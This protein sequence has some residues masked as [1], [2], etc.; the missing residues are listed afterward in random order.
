M[1]KKLLVLLLALML[2][3]AVLTACGQRRPAFDGE[4]DD[5]GPRTGAQ[6]D[7]AGQNDETVTVDGEEFDL[8]Y[9]THHGDLYYKT[10][11]VELGPDTAGAWCE[12]SHY[13]DG[14]PLVRIH[15]VYYE[16]KTAGEVMEESGYELTTKVVGDMEYQYFEYDENGMAGHTYVCSFNGTVY[17]ISFVSNA[18]I[19]ALEQTF[20][21]NVSFR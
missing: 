19:S 17:T 5:A 13:K 12:L 16:G 4:N 1:T 9:E 6:D 8:S 15:L 3:A 11:I 2:A 21:E 14:E 20:M 18:D 7:S 10:D